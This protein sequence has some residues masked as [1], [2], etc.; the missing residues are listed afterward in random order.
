LFAIMMLLMVCITLL[1]LM[2]PTA[3]MVIYIVVG[4]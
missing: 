1:R 3:L 4:V 2:L